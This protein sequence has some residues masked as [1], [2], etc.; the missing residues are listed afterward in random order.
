[1]T[2][3]KDSPTG[4][5]AGRPGSAGLDVADELRRLTARDRWL[6][7]LLDEHQV[8]ST[9][10]IT[11]LA[12]DTAHTARIRLA[13]LHQRRVLAR[14]RDCVRPG[15]QT[16]RWCLG[17]LG[18][19]YVAA[20]DGDSTPR[21]SAVAARAARLATNPQLGHLLGVNQ[22]FVDL[23]A[24]T[25]SHPNAKLSVW[26]SERTAARRV[27]GQLARPDGHG[28][29]TDNGR[30]VSFWLEYDS[31]SEPMRRVIGKLDGYHRL[32]RATGIGHPVL[33]WLH[34]RGREDSLHTH[35]SGHP[36]A[37]DLI[38]AT[39]T[40]DSDPHPAGP[41]WLRFGHTER[42]RLADLSGT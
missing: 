23:A 15:S 19:A 32:H 10:Q 8:L 34:S 2:T 38:I 28:V 17:P 20:R 9:E 39:A 7:D 11:A 37:H 1:M 5:S 31:G 12:F 3:R 40:R 27:T 4:P 41:V 35:A 13:R 21:P 18:A 30:Q 26:W 16:W 25:R 33:F 36:A 6:L 22:F 42:L 14:F 29:W 24:H